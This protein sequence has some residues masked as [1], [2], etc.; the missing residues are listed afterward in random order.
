M[1][2]V[3]N[4]SIFNKVA[5]KGYARKL[6]LKLIELTPG[7]AIVEMVSHKDDTNTLAWYTGVLYFP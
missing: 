7:H 2:D 4:S 1:D 5:K 6:G 3:I